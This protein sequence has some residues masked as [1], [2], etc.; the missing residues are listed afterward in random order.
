MTPQK[1]RQQY[2]NLITQFQSAFPGIDPPES[3]WWQMWMGKYGAFA[4]AEAIRTLSEHPMKSR[5]TQE[6]TGRALTVLL[7]DSA[8][9]QACADHGK[10]VR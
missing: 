1:L 6:S 3:S 4:I 10:A 7:R 2:L 9:K 8:L 5:F